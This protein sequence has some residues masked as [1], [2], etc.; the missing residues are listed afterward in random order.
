MKRKV[1]LITV[2]IVL[3]TAIA[4]CKKGG[5]GS[6]QCDAHVVHQKNI[7]KTKTD[8]SLGV[9]RPDRVAMFVDAVRP[10]FCWRLLLHENRQ[11]LEWLASKLN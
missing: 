1:L 3:A 11:P 2:G 10:A 7:D 5:L 8:I 4:G 6:T 9:E